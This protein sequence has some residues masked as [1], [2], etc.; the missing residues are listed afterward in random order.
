MPG[1][2]TE[3]FVDDWDSGI[4]TYLSECPTCHVRLREGKHPFICPVCR[5]DSAEYEPRFQFYVCSRCSAVFA[6]GCK[7]NT[8]GKRQTEF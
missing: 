1:F 2:P 5:G 4:K 7:A 6:S 8:E 3:P